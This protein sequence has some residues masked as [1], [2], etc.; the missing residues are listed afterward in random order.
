MRGD[1]FHIAVI[2]TANRFRSPIAATSLQRELDGLPV[3][4]TSS[5]TLD[6]GP[7]PPL[8]EA[9]R[10]GRRLGLP[11]GRH[12]AHV[13]EA[14]ELAEADLVLG[15]E[16]AHLVAAVDQGLASPTV[17]FTLPELVALVAQIRPRRSRRPVPTWRANI[18]AAAKSRHVIPQQ[19]PEIGDPI[20]KRVKVAEQ[21]AATVVELSVALGRALRSWV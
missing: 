16:R 13:M 7:L 3:E 9:L 12:R 21:T 8:I 15:F 20:G 10:A 6:V 2:C 18:A 1:R 14:G 4:I 11:V 5:G 17:T 19:V